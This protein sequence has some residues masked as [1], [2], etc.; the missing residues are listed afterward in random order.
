MIDVYFLDCENPAL[1]DD[2]LFRF[3]QLSGFQSIEQLSFLIRRIDIL[4]DD[5]LEVTWHKVPYLVRFKADIERAWRWASGSH[6]AVEHM[7]DDYP[8]GIISD[9]NLLPEH[10]GEEK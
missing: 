3:L 5:L 8:H 10:D 6:L 1:K 2:L 4:G 9:D 7:C